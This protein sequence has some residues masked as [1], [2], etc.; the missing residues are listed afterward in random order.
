M[1]SRFVSVLMSW[2][3]LMPSCV[4]DGATGP[5][6]GAE[7]VFRVL[8]RPYSVSSLFFVAM[9]SFFISVAMSSSS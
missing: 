6:E 1:C 4:R 9:Y 8:V 3:L 5:F 2:L 7:L